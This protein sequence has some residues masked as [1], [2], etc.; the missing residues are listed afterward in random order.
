MLLP[1]LNNCGCCGSSASL[2]KD[3]AAAEPP[4]LGVLCEML[5]PCKLAIL[6]KPVAAIVA[7]C[8]PAAFLVAA[9]AAEPTAV[10][11]LASIAAR[12]APANPKLA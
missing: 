9:A 6:P 8:I 4:P 7:I 12:P 11:L 1:V 2:L 3:G 5:P 10:C